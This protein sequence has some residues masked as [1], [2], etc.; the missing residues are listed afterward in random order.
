LISIK[1]YL[2]R[3]A[4]AL[5]ADEPESN[6]LL[7]VTMESYRAVLRTVGKSAVA[8]C[9]APGRE[10]DRDLTSLEGKLASG[11]TTDGVKK[12][13]ERVEFALE[14][15]GSATAE[16]LKGKTDEVKELLM[17][18]A[19]TAEAVGERD[20]RYAAQFGGLTAE[21]QAIANLDDISQVR[22][23]LVKKATELKSYV[24]QMAQDG[25][26]S[27]AQLR[28]KVSAYE[29]KLE[30]VEELASKDTLTGL[31]NRRGVEARMERHVTLGRMFC[32]VMLDLN[33][34]KAVNDKHGHV[35]GD[36]LLKKFAGELQKNVRNDDLVG[37]WGG[38]EFV[39][40]LVRDLK[41]AE[42]QMHR[43]REWVFGDYTIE[44]GAGKGP[45]KIPVVASVGLAQWEPGKTAKQVVEQADA[46]MYRDK[47]ESLK[48]KK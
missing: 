26:N 32:V 37:R 24:D 25:Q 43:I 39:I 13:Q 29:S 44:T 28:T 5:I 23:S 14:R 22:S 10:L 20:Q 9:P 2:D 4:P 7:T 12:I 31:A 33:L 41:G 27:L 42:A 1:K 48:K 19:R 34:F 46:A 6:E 15:W 38:D 45:V 8:A 35:A 3:D 40:V 17:M 21:L 16:H 18:L 36:D 30:V 11:A 47:K